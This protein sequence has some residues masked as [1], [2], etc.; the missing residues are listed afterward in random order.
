MTYTP[1]PVISGERDLVP[2]TSYQVVVTAGIRSASGAPILKDRFFMMGATAS[3]REFKRRDGGAGWSAP[4]R[5]PHPGYLAWN[6]IAKIKD[7]PEVARCR[8]F[9]GYLVHA[10]LAES[11][12]WSRV[13]YWIKPLGKRPP[14]KRP[15]CEGDGLDAQRFMGLNEGGG[16]IWSQIVCPGD[17]CPFAMGETPPCKLTAHL[18]FQLVFPSESGWPGLPSHLA[19]WSTG[20]VYSTASLAGLFA[21]LLG[22]RFVNPSLPD[23]A[24]EDSGVCGALGIDPASLPL[25]GL[26]FVARIDER[27][28]EAHGGARFPVTTFSPWGDWQE[29]VMRQF[30]ARR[31]LAGGGPVLS[32]GAAPVPA[33]VA[34][35]DPEFEEARVDLV[36]DVRPEVGAEPI[37]DAVVVDAALVAK[38]E[39]VDPE[40]EPM[41]EFLGSAQVY[42][43]ERLCKELG[44]D[45]A[46]LCVSIGASGGLSAKRVSADDTPAA[47]ARRIEAT[48]RAKAG[49]KTAQPPPSSRKK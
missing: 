10:S 3:K 44:V 39:G 13:A 34:V 26:P 47:L 2:K 49:Q 18:T 19:A 36:A 38:D 11:A 16:E 4:G 21:R 48:I 15:M 28:S 12:R 32:L 41:P 8:T 30:R 9:Y 43:L 42:E 24:P 20:S 27:T 46:E 25:L 14:S 33:P 7:H 31:E 5:D 1:L 35:N 6:D 23:G 22:S 45:L 29:W 40:Y 17:L 37:E